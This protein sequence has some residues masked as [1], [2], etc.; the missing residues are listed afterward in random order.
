MAELNLGN[1]ECAVTSV[2]VN[3]INFAEGTGNVTLKYVTDKGIRVGSASV[4]LQDAV[5][6]GA[7]DLEKFGI[8]SESMFDQWKIDNG[9]TIVEEEPEEPVEEPEPSGVL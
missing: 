4:S 5:L 6:A 9:Y 7:I 3:G 2:K 8:L 1:M